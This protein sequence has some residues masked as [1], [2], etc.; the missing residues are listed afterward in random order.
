MPDAVLATPICAKDAV[1]SSRIVFRAWQWKDEYIFSDTSAIHIHLRTGFSSCAT[2]TLLDNQI[3]LH[4]NIPWRKITITRSLNPFLIRR[5]WVCEFRGIPSGFEWNNPLKKT[6]NKKVKE[7]RK[8]LLEALA[9]LFLRQ[10]CVA[11]K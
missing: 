1:S 5:N 7:M 4:C 9:F 10:K 6:R 8:T 2:F 11:A 3:M